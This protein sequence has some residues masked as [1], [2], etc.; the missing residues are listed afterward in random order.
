MFETVHPPTLLLGSHRSGTSA[1]AQRLGEMGLFL[2]ARQDSHAEST[3]FQRLNRRLS[4]EAGGHWTT[5]RVVASSLSGVEDLTSFSEPLHEH[6]QSSAAV[7]FWG[8]GDRRDRLAGRWGWKDP[9][10]TYLLPLWR[11]VFPQL[12]V[13][14]IQ[15]DPRNAAQSLL[16]RTR[17]VRRAIEAESSVRG[18]RRPILGRPLLVDGWRALSAE[19]ALEI[20]LTY[21]EIQNEVL[22]SAK[23][24]ATHV[25]DY[26]RLLENPT[27]ELSACARFCGLD[28]SE[29]V[30]RA[31]AHSIT[32]PVPTVPDGGSGQGVDTVTVVSEDHERR[33]RLLG[34]S[35]PDPA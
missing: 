3:F 35:T 13:V 30:V 12:Q 25:V 20:V 17:A 34:Y 29:E 27:T 6:V 26:E 8:L 28:V 15:R 24:V 7:E 19:G 33:L 18:S 23:G 2:G 11:S 14:A 4:Y 9:R 21:R 31:Q 16:V 5:P 32:R 10:N 1:V 22:V